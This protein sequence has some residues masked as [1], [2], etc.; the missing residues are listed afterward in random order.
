LANPEDLIYESIEKQ[1]KVLPKKIE[2]EYIFGNKMKA[3]SLQ[4]RRAIKKL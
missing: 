3:N 2:M 1:K 4:S